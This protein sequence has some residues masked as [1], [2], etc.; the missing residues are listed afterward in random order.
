MARLIVKE[1]PN[2]GAVFE[3]GLNPAIIGRGD[4][5]DI[6]LADPTVSRHHATVV[7]YAKGRYA[8][9]DNSSSCGVCVNGRT[10]DQAALNDGDLLR[11]GNCQ[12]E[13]AQDAPA[14]AD[15]SSAERGAGAERS[16]MT[17]MHV[18]DGESATR[19][20]TS[21][22]AGN[23]AAS[24]AERHLRAAYEISGT[25]SAGLD[26]NELC[27]KLLGAIFAAIPADR[28]AIFLLDEET[29]TVR[30]QA[31]MDSLGRENDVPFSQTIVRQV[32]TKGES[33]LFEDV[34]DIGDL[35]A[36]ASIVVNHI[37]SAMC[38]PLR[39]R[40]KIAGTIHVD[41]FRRNVFSFDDLQLLTIIG[42]QVGMMIHIARLAEENV[43]A[44]R[45]A[46]VGQTVASLAHC[47]K[48]ILQGLKGGAYMVDEGLKS[49]IPELVSAGWPIV[50]N[51][52]Q[53]I[54]ELVMNMLDY[55]KERTP[56]YERAD[57]REHLQN[58]GD[59]MQ[60][61]ARDKDVTLEFTCDDAMPEVD[62]DPLAIYRAVLN[63][64]T[65]AI[66][67]AEQGGRRVTLDARPDACGG[68]VEISVT[69]NG[70]G[71]P[72]EVEAK[73]FEAFHSTKA[74]KGTG[75][76]LA[77]TKK[78]VEEHRGRIFI[79][80]EVGKGTTFAIVLPVARPPNGDGAR[81]T[82]RA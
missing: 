76:G 61:R 62:C 69:D 57:L 58:I 15:G 46:A 60:E 80:T 8:I 16:T 13:F 70:P 75:L 68:A 49:A 27:R 50:K 63:L 64:V 24:V 59:L 71:I 78:I 23:D 28:A 51:N 67:A 72:P 22:V 73:L 66:D 38:V 53:R 4:R 48:N 9:H 6:R 31:A 42:N 18:I 79:S 82:A 55:S 20:A 34:Q 7:S 12:L 40:E 19:A 54:S 21:G 65:N 25:I 74:S 36:A 52:Q 39:V 5:S 81:K 32:L 26:L 10:V 45:L 56:A 2:R 77:V 41:A 35:A 17:I 47:I 1:G 14:A 30:T 37:R 11:I 33:L 43:K 3:L 44:A 29:G